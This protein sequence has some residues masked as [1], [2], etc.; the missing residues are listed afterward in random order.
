MGQWRQRNDQMIGEHAWASRQPKLTPGQ[1]LAYDRNA[2]ENPNMNPRELR[3]RAM[4]DYNLAPTNHDRNAQESGT[5]GAY[6]KTQQ[7]QNQ[8]QNPGQQQPPPA[9]TGNLGNDNKGGNDAKVGGGQPTPN[10]GAGTKA[11]AG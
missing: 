11:P 7:Q 9:P 6:Q 10:P 3:S 2:S 8:Q 4:E 1:Q 5:W